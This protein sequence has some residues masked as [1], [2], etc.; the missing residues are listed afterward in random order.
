[1]GQ[2]I[3]ATVRVEAMVL[4][5]VVVQLNLWAQVLKLELGI[6]SE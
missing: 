4:I 6:I 3:I 1:M 5:W 2:A